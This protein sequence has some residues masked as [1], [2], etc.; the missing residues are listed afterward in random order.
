MQTKPVVQFKN[1]KK[2]IG[3]KMIIL[4]EELSLIH[5]I[6]FQQLQTAQRYEHAYASRVYLYT[7]F[8]LTNFFILFPP[9]FA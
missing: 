3:K 2:K 7:L 5:N 8:F 9:F 1:I 6:P 4:L